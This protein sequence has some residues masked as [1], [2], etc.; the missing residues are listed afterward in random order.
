MSYW[1]SSYWNAGH[2]TAL[3]WGPRAGEI[4]FKIVNST[5]IWTDISRASSGLVDGAFTDTTVDGALTLVGEDGALYAD[6]EWT[7]VSRTTS[8]WAKIL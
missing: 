1:K 2:F 5:D 4:W 8:T 7:E 3:Y 6:T